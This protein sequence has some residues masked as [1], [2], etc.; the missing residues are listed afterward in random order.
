VVCVR[1]AV[2]DRMPPATV[3]SMTNPSEASR[4]DAANPDAQRK[5]WD[6]LF[7]KDGQSLAPPPRP[8]DAVGARHTRRGTTDCNT[9]TR[10]VWSRGRHGTPSLWVA[11][12]VCWDGRLRTAVSI[13]LFRKNQN[14]WSSGL[15]VQH[16][17]RCECRRTGAPGARVPSTRPRRRQSPEWVHS[18][19]Y[20]SARA[21][22]VSSHVL[23]EC[24]QQPDHCQGGQ[25]AESDQSETP[26]RLRRRCSLHADLRIHRRFCRRG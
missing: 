22:I 15:A 24:D 21:S 20:G 6:E 7:Q 13:R 1:G 19:A 12:G 9:L 23:E 8:S 2:G 18:L 26:Q 17:I 16:L 25:R 3:R 10:G 5:S 11:V 4:D 14:L